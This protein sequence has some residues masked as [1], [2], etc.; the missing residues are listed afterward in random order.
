MSMNTKKG[1]GGGGG[2]LDINIRV[3][4]CYLPY[5]DPH[6][7]LVECLQCSHLCVSNNGNVAF[8]INIS[9]T[10]ALI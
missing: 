10:Y 6:R 3:L 4:L 8:E 7:L 2:R 5:Q 9:T 1:G